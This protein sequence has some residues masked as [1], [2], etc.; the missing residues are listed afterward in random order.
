[1]P[2]LAFQLARLIAYN[3]ATSTPKAMESQSII[4]TRVLAGPS[5]IHSPTRPPR[6]YSTNANKIRPIKNAILN[7][8]SF[9]YSW[10]LVRF[11]LVT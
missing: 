11:F 7:L 3:N 5:A 9:F 8:L 6:A 4:L 2:L 1:M 10:L